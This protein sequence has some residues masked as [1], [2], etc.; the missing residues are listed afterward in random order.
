MTLSAD[1]HDRDAVHNYVHHIVDDHHEPTG[2]PRRR[3]RVE[4]GRRALGPRAATRPWTVLKPRHITRQV[5]AVDDKMGPANNGQCVRVL[6]DEQKRND[7]EGAVYKRSERTFCLLA[8][9]PFTLQDIVA[10]GVGY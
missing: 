3:S 5:P 8:G 10:Y 7:V 1:I 4:P 2:Q 6:R 9:H